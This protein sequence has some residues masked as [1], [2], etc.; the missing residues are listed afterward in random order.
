MP[1]LID[2]DKLLNAMRVSKFVGMSMFKFGEDASPVEIVADAMID[3][4]L[5]APT[6]DVKP[7]IHAYPIFDHKRNYAKCS[8][9][10]RYTIGY[11]V[12]NWDNYCSVCGAKMDG[13]KDG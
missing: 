13:E 9:C 10:K 11:D 6:V 2:A 7:T 5:D 3:D 1:R 4:V 12:D 8:N